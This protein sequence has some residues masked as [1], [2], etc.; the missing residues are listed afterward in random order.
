MI[1]LFNPEKNEVKIDILPIEKSALNFFRMMLSIRLAEK[2]LASAKENNLI[3]GPIHLGVGQEAIAVGI[4]SELRSSDR[5]FGAHRSHAHIL[6]MNT[7]FKALF[8]EVLGRKTG[9]SKGM[10]GSMHL[11]DQS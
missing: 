8:A 1:D 10:G 7:N 3:G 11:W 6:A 5:V 2:Q 9:F 4:A